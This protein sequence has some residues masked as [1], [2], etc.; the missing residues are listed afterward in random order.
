M[1]N[2][3]FFTKMGQS[4][5]NYDEDEAVRLAKMALEKGIDPVVGI[6]E[7]FIKGIQT[8]GDLF[9]RGEIFLP[10]LVM[11]AEAMAAAT[12]ILEEAVKKSGQKPKYLAQG[13]AGTVEG[14]IHDIGI[15]LVTTLLVV[16]GFDIIFLGTDIPSSLFVEKAKELKP[17]LVLLS[18]LVTTTMPKQKEV[19]DR[20]K[21]AGIRE[22]VKVLV[23]GAPVSQGWADQIGA[24]GYAENAVAAVEVVKRLIGA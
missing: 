7:G 20:L 15:R 8:M 16:N 19:I 13:I 22:R 12:G 5:I 11:A 14:D 3:E 17:D 9:S 1:D 23:G 2:K 6:D 18:A 21:E 10:D 24:D 4:I